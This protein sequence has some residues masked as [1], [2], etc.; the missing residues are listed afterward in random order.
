[1]LFTGDDCALLLDLLAT[2]TVSPLETSAP[3]HLWQAQ[4]SYASAAEALGFHVL[5]HAAPPAHVLD[6]DDVPAAVRQAGPEFLDDQP[7]LVLRL[8][9]ELPRSETIMFN[10]HLDTVAGLEPVGLHDGRFTGR[11]AIDA[12]GPAVALLSGI[13]AAVN[14]EPALGREVSVLVQAVA[15]EEG[16][17]M[18][19]FGT[20]PLV[21][22]G[23][24]GRLN[25]CCEPT[26]L[27]YLP[28]STASMTARVCVDGHSAIDDR[29][30]AGHNA[31]VLLGFLAQ[32]L[33]ARLDP[34]NRPGRLCIAGLHTGDR[35]NRVYGSGELLLNLSYATTREGAA[36]EAALPAEI[37]SG[38]TRFRDLF[39]D[40][41]EFARTAGDAQKI[42]RVEWLKRGLPCLNNTDPWAE[43][44]LTRA[45][46]VR[47]PADKPGFTCDAI[48]LHELADG[49]TAVLGPGHLDTN[50]A[51]AEGE[52]ADR[53][54]LAEFAA[55]ISTLL[56]GF[57]RQRTGKE[58]RDGSAA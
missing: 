30:D 43:E 25:I 34:A 11:G 28:R 33:A 41:R 52:H 58:Q 46:V 21:E 22:Q 12:K 8:G 4:R 42:T 3:P 49:Y 35:H 32:H 38:L 54:E 20:R 53:A 16:G 17:A 45:G 19:T 55:I 29:P 40:T 24:V 37:D 57:V 39:A 9:P 5:H 23:Y 15:G 2:P 48:W 31:S 13:R 36:A 10:V 50:H 56:V 6:R 27:R 47:W 51:H 26:G 1:M 14:V 44:L 7:S 18:G